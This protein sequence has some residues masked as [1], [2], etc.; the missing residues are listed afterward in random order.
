MTTPFLCIALALGL[1]Y[2]PRIMVAVAQSRM[3]EGF[4]NRHPRDQQA[5]LTGWGKRAQGAHMNAF[6]AFA[7]FAAA[8]IVA[9]LAR[10]D[11]RYSAILAVVFVIARVVYTVLYVANKDRLRSAVWMIGLGATV[12]LFVLPYL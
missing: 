11:A 2:A 5:R 9:H 3:P 8:V 4:D 7:P 1:I 6:E 12:G 10:A